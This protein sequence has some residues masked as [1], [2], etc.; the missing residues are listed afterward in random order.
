MQNW[1]ER[2]NVHLADWNLLYVKFHHF[3][4]YV[5]GPH[6]PALHAK[7]EELYDMAA[8]AL[9]ELAERMLA[10]GLRPAATLKAYGELATI[11]EAESGLTDADMVRQAAEDVAALARDM[12]RTAES[13]EKAGD[14]ATSDL[15]IGQVKALQKQGWM[16]SAMAGSREPARV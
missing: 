9:D 2:L 6:F 8:S 11:K 14:A 5:A 4:W 10:I 13:A 3:H 12:E 16:L 7:F 15:L 1:R